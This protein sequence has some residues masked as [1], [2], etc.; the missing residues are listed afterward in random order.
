MALQDHP[1]PL[2]AP[3]GSAHP[4]KEGKGQRAEGRPGAQEAMIRAG[5]GRLVRW[6]P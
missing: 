2:S 1:F 3:N 4:G 6:C 5:T